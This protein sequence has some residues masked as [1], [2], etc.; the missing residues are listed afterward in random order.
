[1][2]CKN[3]FKYEICIHSLKLI[4]RQCR[5]H[6]YASENGSSISSDN[7]LS[8]DQC[9]AIIW[10][11]AGILLIEH[12]G[13]NFNEIQIKIQNF[14]FMKMHLKMLSG[15]WHPFDPGG[16][17]LTDSGLVARYRTNELIHNW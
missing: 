10:T 6:A 3:N 2:L 1:M 11:N 14:S 12:L 15:K 7:G 16:D 8:P 17:E 9:E 4:F 13:R 5:N